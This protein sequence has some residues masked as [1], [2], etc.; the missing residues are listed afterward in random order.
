MPRGIQPCVFGSWID[1]T[2]GYTTSDQTGGNLF[3]EESKV[4]FERVKFEAFKNDMAMYR[5]INFMS[6]EV[7]KAY[8]G[9]KIPVRKTKYSAGYDICIPIDISIPSGQRRVIPTGIKVV[10][11]EDEMSTW[12]LQMYVRSS[13]GIKDGIV[14]TNGTG[15]IDPDY[16]RG[17]NDGDMMLALLN[18]SDKLVQYKAGDRICQAVFV[19][20]GLT[21]DDNASGDRIG[22]IGSTK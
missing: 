19:I 14:L 13:V 10:F 7:E 2:R 5:P 12:H 15:V 18:T 6:G 1:N 21:S 3:R 8:D 17:K 9:I 20:H 16:F 22:G 4:H 11:E